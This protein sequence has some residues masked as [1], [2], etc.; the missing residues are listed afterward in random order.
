M[1][2]SQYFYAKALELEGALLRL[3]GTS[4]HRSLEAKTVH[5]ELTPPIPEHSGF[6]LQGFSSDD[7]LRT[8]LESYYWGAA[9][10][11]DILRDSSKDLPYL[12]SFE[13]PGVRD[14]RNH[15]VQHPT[16]KRGVPVYS[17]AYGGPA[18]PQLKPIRAADDPPGSLDDGLL[19]NAAEF[20][21]A[22][23]KVLSSAVTYL[24]A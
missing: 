2:D 5:F 14:V 4:D 7:E 23:E 12:S 22:L 17:F 3:D 1:R 16:K 24:M 9:R 6:V 21:D 15:L 8:T 18:G 19:S 11:R 13:A 20:E 10:V